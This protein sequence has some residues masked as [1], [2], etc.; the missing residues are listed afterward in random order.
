[1][2]LRI[3]SQNLDTEFF[4]Y[5]DL[6]AKRKDLKNRFRRIKYYDHDPLNLNSPRDAWPQN[7]GQ[8]ISRVTRGSLYALDGTR[9]LPVIKLY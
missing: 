8:D 6:I 7:L 2:Q 3:R 5:Q 1:M 4:I 9:I